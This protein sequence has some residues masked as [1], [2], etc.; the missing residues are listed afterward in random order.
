MELITLQN[1]CRLCFL[2]KN[3]NISIFANTTTGL[4]IAQTI[5]KYFQS[6]VNKKMF[7]MKFYFNEK[8]ILSLESS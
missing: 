8:H 2:T 4:N 5:E 1:C 3:E 6:E 7:Q